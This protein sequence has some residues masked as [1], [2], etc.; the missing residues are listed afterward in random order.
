MAKAKTAFLTVLGICLAIVG[1]IGL[2]VPILPGILFLGLAAICFSA[3]SPAVRR[4]LENHPRVVALRERFVDA[5]GVS[6]VERAKL[7]LLLFADSII[8]RRGAR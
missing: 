7:R 2:V 8:G 6:Y 4:R 3:D 5:D 1:V